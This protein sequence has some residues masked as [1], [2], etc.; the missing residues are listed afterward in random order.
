MGKPTYNA[1]LKYSLE[2]PV[3]IFVPSRKQARLTAIDLLTYTAA[4]NQPNRFI[5]AEEDDIKPFL[6]KISD[7]VIL[8]K[9]IKCIEKLEFYW[10]F[11]DLDIKRNFAP[12]SGIFT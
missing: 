7:K 4:D 11:M 8:K 5:H 9:Q 10:Y 3:I 2:K 1:I 12:R 6:E